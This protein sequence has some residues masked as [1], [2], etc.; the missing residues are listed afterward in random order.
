M[1]TW[2]QLPFN[3]NCMKISI[4]KSPLDFTLKLP[5]IMRTSTFIIKKLKIR[6]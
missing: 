4:K 6:T 5:E 3:K 2:S 1:L